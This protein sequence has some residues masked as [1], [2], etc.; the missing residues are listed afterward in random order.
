M[1]R[2]LAWVALALLATYIVFVGGSWLGLYWPAVRIATMI[3]ATAVLVVW[4]LVAIRSPAWRPR[5]VLLP[6]ILACLVSLAASSA[7]SRYP[8]ISIEYLGYAFV[9]AAL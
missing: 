9:L 4:L 1:T 5:S 2:R 7:T 8:T 6:A 3:I